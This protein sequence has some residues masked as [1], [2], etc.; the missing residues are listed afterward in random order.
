M[1]YNPKQAF[2]DNLEAIRVMFQLERSELAAT[3]QQL[4][5]LRRYSGFGGLRCILLPIDDLSTWSEA[6]KKLHYLVK[7]LEV[8]LQQNAK[9]ENEYRRYL[10]HI[11]FST[12]TAFYTPRKITDVIAACLYESGVE[13]GTILEPSCGNGEFIR[14]FLEQGGNQASSPQVTGFEQEIVTSKICQLIYPEHK[15][16]SAGFER[17]SPNLLNH[18]DLVVSNIPFGDTAVY[19]PLFLKDTQRKQAAQKVHCYFFMKALDTLHDKGVLAFI[20]SRGVLDSPSN[21]GIREYLMTHADLVSAIR[22]PNNTFENTK[23]GCDLIVLQKNDGKQGTSSKEEEFIATTVVDGITTN[24]LLSSPDHVV[25]SSQYRGKDL[26]GKEALVYIQQEGIV[27]IAQHLRDILSKD[28]QS[29][30][31]TEQK[32]V[33]SNHAEI[34]PTITT[35]SP[36]LSLYD[37]YDA[38]ENMKTVVS[39]NAI[40]IR[41]PPIKKR[42]KGKETNDKN[43]MGDIFSLPSSEIVDISF[44]SRP[45]KSPIKNYYKDGILVS[46]QG[47]VGYLR[48]FHKP[49]P[50]FHPLKLDYFTQGKLDA[51]VRLRDAYQNLYYY[52][53]ERREINQELRYALNQEY[54]SFI[55][56]YGNLNSKQ[57]TKHILMDAVGIEILSL[58]RFANGVKYK[59]DIFDKPV[60]FSIEEIKHTDNTEEALAISLNNFGRVDFNYITE[61]TDKD[62]DALLEELKGQVYYNPIHKDYETSSKFLSGDVV[63][64]ISLIEE[65]LITHPD[66]EL[67]KES[68]KALK[69]VAPEQITFD[70]LD[71]NLG[72]RWIPSEVY[73]DF[74]SNLFE[75]EV[76]I[77]LI[78]DWDQF[79]I[80]CSSRNAIINKKFSVNS[81]HDGIE[82]LHHALYNTAPIITK[83]VMVDGE[84]RKVVDNEATQLAGA[85]IEE[86][87]NA[88]PVWLE[89]QS[90][91]LKDDL[92]N[93]YNKLFNNSVRPEYDGSHQK[94]PNLNLKGLGIMDLY[95]SQKDCIWMLKQNNGGI[96]DHE[97]G[98]GKTLIMAVASQEM[99]RLG[100]VYKPMILALPN[101]VDQIIETCKTAYPKAKILST[102]KKEFT[103]KQR[104]QF[105]N[106]IRNNN[107]D[108]VILTHDQFSKIP[109]SLE[110]QR[111][112]IETELESIRQNLE[113]LRDKGFNISKQLEK[114]VLKRQGNLEAKLLGINYTMTSRKDD[115]VDF[116]M[117]GIDHIFVDESHYQNFF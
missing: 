38:Q 20:T 92:V 85:K 16:N 76:K 36:L 81:R 95:K 109:Q 74:V 10:R 5:A 47:Q 14:S 29:F 55:G 32:Q 13:I 77:E 86:I 70:E 73:S 1:S 11:R 45:Y 102:T 89:N 64:K 72:E 107:W 43:E 80:N 60:N 9:D 51:Y 66:D 27:K 103:P 78:V 12:L 3:S 17:I 57:N 63:E 90:Q 42:N 25:F 94:F 33:I 84:E 71:F 7:E 105:F 114:G 91:V 2:L 110:I 15:I 116:G 28:I 41:K 19:D 112:T 59:A 46:D 65:Y 67:S 34:I 23:V 39:N 98:L 83:K 106:S 24:S 4:Q 35:P 62:Q 49:I 44:E 30:F 6:D 97:V 99:K 82:L 69:Q 113:V 58:E 75:T 31:Q 93:C 50:I 68:C 61:L 104:V 26:Y 88:F 48:D 37:L 117:L 87:R 108:L 8:L 21:Q 115:V 22:L 53:A 56:Y 54:N 100:L 111:L 52:E 101:N 79:V 96:C 40:E 18:F